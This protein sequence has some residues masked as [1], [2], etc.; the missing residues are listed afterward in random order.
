MKKL[1]TLLSA[2]SLS[3]IAF[4]QMYPIGHMSI[5]FKD[6]SRTGGYA[7]SGGVQMPGT[8]RDVGTEVYYPAVSAGTNV[9]V[10]SGTFPIVVIGHGFLMTYDNYDN[11]YNALAAKGY[12]VAL[13]RTEGSTSPNHADFGADLRLLASQLLTL[14]TVSTPSN[15]V[16]FN[17]KVAQFSAIGGHSMGGGCSFLGAA[18]NTTLTCLFNLAAAN[19]NTAAVSSIQ[20][21]SMV[22]VP[23]LVIGGQRDCVADTSNN[24]NLMY[25]NTASAIKFKVILK[26]LTH[27]DFGN[28]SSFNC[29]FGQGSTGCGNTISNIAAFNRYMTYLEPFLA[30]LLKNDCAKGQQFMDTIQAVS[31]VRVGRKMQGSI[32]CV[33][34]SLTNIDNEEVVALFPNPVADILNIHCATKITQLQVTNVIGEEIFI[35]SIATL[36]ADGFKLD[37]SGLSKGFYFLSVISDNKKISKKFLKQ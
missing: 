28:G 10:A 17:G 1:F 20:S 31:S 4:A 24:Q 11:I 32:A 14:N 3:T 33:A 27:C 13:P 19:S 26:D 5:N 6:A 37:V 30:R 29:T 16:T 9:A 12:I 15:I 18:N 34:T 8:G 7:I 21:A 36:A 2:L 25:N 35:E 23:T 22:T